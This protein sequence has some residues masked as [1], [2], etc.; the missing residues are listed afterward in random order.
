MNA[1][2][3]G[4][5]PGR[6]QYCAKPW[7]GDSGCPKQTQIW[8]MRAINGRST[9]A[10]A[11]CGHAGFPYRLAAGPS[12]S[13]LSWCNRPTGLSAKDDLMERVWPGAVVG[14]G[15]IHV[16]ISAVRK[17][18][19][20]DR[21]MLKTAS[22]R[23]YRLLGSWTPR[24]REGTAP[25]GFSRLIGTSGTPPSSNFPPL[26]NR[27]IGRAAAARFVRDLVSAYRVVTLTGPVASGRPPWLSSRPLL[28]PRL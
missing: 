17:A 14:E 9:S 18:L 21:A 4:L 12:K 2:R 20:P 7:P 19:G 25:P 27:L 24:P 8:C 1:S 15:T 16:H 5:L 10:G 3:V 22:G 6:P 23:G 26:I 28:T 11:S 13:S